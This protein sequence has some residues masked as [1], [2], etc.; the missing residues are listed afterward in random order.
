MRNK[1]EEEI[2]PG[3]VLCT[4]RK[5][6]RDP[7]SQKVVDRWANPYGGRPFLFRQGIDKDHLVLSNPKTGKDVHFGNTGYTSIHKDF[8]MP[9][10]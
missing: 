10:C 6:M 2:M 9:C 7:E 8:V 5:F 1:L 4:L 3:K